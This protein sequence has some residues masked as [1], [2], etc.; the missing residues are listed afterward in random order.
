MDIEFDLDDSISAE[1]AARVAR[2]A[3]DKHHKGAPFLPPLARLLLVSND[4]LVDISYQ[5]DAAREALPYFHRKLPEITGPVILPDLG[6]CETVSQITEAQAK[7][8]QMMSRGQLS[9]Q[10]GK[11]YIESLALMA[12]TL[13]VAHGG[14]TRTLHIIGGMPDLDAGDGT[15]VLPKLHVEDGVQ[16]SDDVRVDPKAGEKAA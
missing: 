13:E 6:P 2:A 15:V 1:A 8:I 3:F 10:T 16:P 7:V 4:P 9:P 5:V 11:T 14:G 12:R